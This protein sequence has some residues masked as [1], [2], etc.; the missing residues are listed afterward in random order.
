MY[1]YVRVIQNK[2]LNGLKSG[3]LE[4]K[5]VYGPGR[6]CFRS[7]VPAFARVSFPSRAWCVCMCACGALSMYAHGLAC[8]RARAG[9]RVCRACPSRE[10]VVGRVLRLSPATVTLTVISN[11]T[12]ASIC[13]PSDLG[14]GLVHHQCG[15][16]PSGRSQRR[17]PIVQPRQ[18][19]PHPASRLQ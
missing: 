4:N 16:R 6:C 9:M 8:V 13:R 11:E 5:K 12:P 7:N 18:R 19:L 14:L 15:G 1:V 2:Q 3:M 17:R 10:N